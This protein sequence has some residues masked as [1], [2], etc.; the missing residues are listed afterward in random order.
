MLGISITCARIHVPISNRAKSINEGKKQVSEV[1]RV[2]FK[3]INQ[4]KI[5][6]PKK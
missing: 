3:K 6:N 5:N 4:E 2:Y 1:E